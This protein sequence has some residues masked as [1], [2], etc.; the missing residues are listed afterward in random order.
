M[1]SGHARRVTDMQ[2]TIEL[3]NKSIGNAKRR[4]KNYKKRLLAKCELLVSRLADRGITVAR[5]NVPSRYATYIMFTKEMS[6][7]DTD[8]RCL[9]IATQ[10]GTIR[11]Y[12]R[13]L[14]TANGV[15]YADVSPLLMTEFG[16]GVQADLNPKGP[17]LGFGRGSFPGQTHAQDSGGWYWLDLSGEWHHSDGEVPT[18]PMQHAMDEMYQ[19][20]HEVVK[21][22]FG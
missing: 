20:I 6:R 18:M 10:T 15:T 11:R 9:M 1:P 13:S 7:S 22:V 21:E 8:C 2:I 19:S 4:L 5:A 16:S 14:N 17:Q 3:S 12:W